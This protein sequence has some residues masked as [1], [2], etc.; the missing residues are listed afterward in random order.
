MVVPTSTPDIL[1]IF[2][3][4]PFPNLKEIQP[5]SRRQNTKTTPQQKT[6]KS[7]PPKKQKQTLTE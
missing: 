2:A 6:A 1:G 5:D 7:P 4:K 3:E